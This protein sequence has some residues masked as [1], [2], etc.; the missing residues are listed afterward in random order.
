MRPVGV[1]SEFCDDLVSILL[2]GTR[3][4]VVRTNKIDNQ[5]KEFRI[6]PIMVG[7]TGHQHGMR[8]MKV[9]VK[10]S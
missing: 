6:L 7:G 2:A 5:L 10:E 3:G 8:N 1:A 4:N 9:F